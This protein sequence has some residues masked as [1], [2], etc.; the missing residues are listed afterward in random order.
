MNKL[1]SFTNGLAKK[2][3]LWQMV[4]S[5]LK[6]S[7]KDLMLGY[8]WW[9]LEPLLFML[10]Y[11]LLVSVIFQRGGRNYPLFILCGLVPFR[12]FAISFSQSVSSIAGKFNLINQIDFPRLFL[13]LTDVIV[14]HF[15]LIFGMLVVLA[16][17]IFFSVD[18]TLNTFLLVI[19]FMCQ[20]LFVTGIALITSIA[21][22]YFRDLKNIMQFSMRL[23]LYASP[24]IYSIDRIP[25][26]YRTFYVLN[27]V[28][29]WVLSYRAIIMDGV[30]P[31]P[32]LTLVSFLESALVLL[33]GLL[34]FQAQDKKILKLY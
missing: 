9:I 12:A 33:A 31:D 14:N 32:Q 25:D 29:T 24:I 13:P 23:L 20:L 16:F 11:W 1:S 22:V 21:G 4:I 17:A 19:P 8:L 5:K 30:P 26:Q 3:L 10:V 7:Q 15:K 18:L 27:P 34:F 28:A 2:D 6:V